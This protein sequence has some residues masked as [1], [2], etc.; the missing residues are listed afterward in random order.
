MN[1]SPSRP[2]EPDTL[3]SLEQT[4]AFIARHIG[5]TP[6][7]QAAMLDALGY[8]SRRAL[9]D[10]IVP[11]VIRRRGLLALPPAIPEAAA[12]ARL[13]QSLNERPDAKRAAELARVQ[14]AFASAEESAARRP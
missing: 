8:P 12:L 9:M 5:T 7:D 10:A 13:R 2:G 11:A 14:A 4:D 3:A 1:D 6:A